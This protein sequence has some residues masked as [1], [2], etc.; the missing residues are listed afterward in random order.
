[1]VVKE[2]RVDLNPH[3]QK[4][5]VFGRRTVLSK[6]ISGNWV[7]EMK[8]RGIEFAG[9]RSY[10]YGDDASLI[11]WRASL[12][13]KE[14]LVREFEEYKSFSVFILL[15]VS[16]SML[17]SSTEKLKAEYAAEMAFSLAEGILRN[18]NAVGLGM[19]TDKLEVSMYPEIGKGVLDRISK[20][21]QNPERYGGGFDIKKVLRQTVSFLRSNAILLIISDFIGLEDGWERYIRM[22]AGKFELIGLMV[23]DPR[24]HALPRNTGQYLLKDPYSPESLYVDVNDVT[25]EFSEAAEKEEKRIRAVFEQVRGGLALISTDKDYADPIMRFLRRRQFVTVTT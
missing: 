9:Y 8:G 11:D 19:F 3:L 22:M 13:A 25:K 21:L 23:R 15:D 7:T 6:T 18:G 16:N 1:M 12:R 24:D 10:A 4:A 14:T 5:E 17:F 20:E 2:L